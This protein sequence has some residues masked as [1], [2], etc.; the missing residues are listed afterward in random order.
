MRSH[1]LGRNNICLLHIESIAPAAAPIESCL[2][3]SAICE[4]EETPREVASTPPLSDEMR[5]SLGVPAPRDDPP[6][7]FYR[8]QMN[9]ILHRNSISCYPFI[10]HSFLLSFIYDRIYVSISLSLPLS[11]PSPPRPTDAA[12][13]MRHAKLYY[14]NI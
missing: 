2:C 12:S 1:G 10:S 7:P 14:I 3:L 8:E 4:G 13:T 5:S 11:T 6:A 9:V